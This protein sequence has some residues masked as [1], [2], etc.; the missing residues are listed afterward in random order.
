MPDLHLKRKRRSHENVDRPKSARVQERVELHVQLESPAA[1][2]VGE[3][4]CQLTT[5]DRQ[6]AVV[7]VLGSSK[8]C[9]LRAHKACHSEP[10]SDEIPQTKGELDNTCAKI[11]KIN[12]CIT[13]ELKTC[14]LK[15]EE[16]V[17]DDA[18]WL[19]WRQANLN[20]YLPICEKDSD[21]YSKFLSSMTCIKNILKDSF[22]EESCESAVDDAFHVLE[23]RLDRRLKGENNTVID[24]YENCLSSLLACNCGINLHFRDCGSDARTV[25]FQMLKSAQDWKRKCPSDIRSE[26]L[27]WLDYLSSFT[28]RDIPVK[29]YLKTNIF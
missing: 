19:E 26:I 8:S 21:L 13:N 5:A 18:N 4:Q 1:D 2:S 14:Y 17:D 20:V 6:F 23:E 9:Q 11:Q 27:E 15:D 22:M 28:R 12:R 24:L 16:L 7:G 10:L 25:V 29:D 3:R